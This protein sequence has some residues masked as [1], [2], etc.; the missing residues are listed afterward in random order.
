MEGNSPGDKRPTFSVEIQANTGSTYFVVFSSFY[1]AVLFGNL[2]NANITSFS[3]VVGFGDKFP[4]KPHHR[5]ASCPPQISTQCNKGHETSP[6][7]NPSTIFVSFLALECSF[8][9]SRAL[10]L[11][12]RMLKISLKTVVVTTSNLKWHSTITPAS[13]VCVILNSNATCDNY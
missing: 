5:G 9:V 2:S 13:K 4:G 3:Y 10:S 7:R 8:T 12:V 11:A 1:L 6:N